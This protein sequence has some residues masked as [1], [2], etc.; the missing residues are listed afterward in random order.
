MCAKSRIAKR[1]LTIPRLELAAGHMTVNLASN[2]EAALS[3]NY[4]VGI[5]CWL[6]STV[7]LYCIKGRRDYRQFVANRVQKIQQH[8]SSWE[9]C[10]SMRQIS[11]RE[12]VEIA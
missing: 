11:L 4:E 10:L 12:R 8:E 6:D 2:V 1:N 3:M 7:A 5:N 9:I